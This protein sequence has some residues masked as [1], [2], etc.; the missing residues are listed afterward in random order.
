[1]SFTINLYTN[2][3]E[4]NK[5]DKS[6]DLVE[7]YTG[8][9]RAE[10]SII[11]PKI[12]IECD[13]TLLARCNYLSIP[14]FRRYYYIR[15]MVSVREG[16]VELT[17]HVDV[18]MSFASA[19]KSNRA[20]IKRSA[21]E[22]NLYLNDGSLKCYQNPHIITRKFPSGFSSQE[23]VMAV[24]GAASSSSASGSSASGSSASSST[25]SS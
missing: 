24:A 10:C 2:Y 25:S 3:S 23:F 11:D 5:V 14:S 19:I 8:V 20:I 16:L 1:M 22:W 7:S 9:L 15:D 6:I 17:C 21:T 18:L 12:L 4:S 13:I